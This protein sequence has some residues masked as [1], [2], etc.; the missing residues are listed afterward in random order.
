MRELV[1]R[2][3][4]DA[5]EPVLDELLLLAPHGVFERERGDEVELWLR[6]ADDEL[7]PRAAVVAAA[8]AWG[9][10]LR[11]HEVSDDWRERRADDHEPLVVA[12]RLAVRPGWARRPPDG[13][14]DVVLH[15]EHAFGIGAHPTTRACLEVLC[16]LEPAG[17]FLDL[18]CGSGVL[19]IAAALLGWSPV[20]AI[21]N[22]PAAVAAATANAAASGVVVDVREGDIAAA[23]AEPASVIVANVPL[24]AHEKL[25]A[26]LPQPPP[27]MIV[28][29]IVDRDA[30]DVSGLYTARGARVAQRFV[31][32]DWAILILAGEALSD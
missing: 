6:G 11:E 8:G 32:Q 18:G 4:A 26:A 28:A 9:D 27:L 19:A 20:V 29:G 31:T 1:L 2:V 5:V 15:D 3:P 10:S 24:G 17:S 22:Q 25:A 23:A 16:A 12:Q 30:D 14:L 13:L 21:D 7:P